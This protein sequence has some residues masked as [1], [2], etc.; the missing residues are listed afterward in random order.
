MYMQQ[1]HKNSILNKF[2]FSDILYLGQDA[3]FVKEYAYKQCYLLRRA[4]KNEEAEIQINDLLRMLLKYGVIEKVKK[5]GLKRQIPHVISYIILGYAAVKPSWYSVKR[6]GQYVEAI[7]EAL[8]KAIRLE[9]KWNFD[10]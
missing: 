9:P 8:K 6:R 4:W 2:K 10:F 5:D 7:R 1:V 3:R